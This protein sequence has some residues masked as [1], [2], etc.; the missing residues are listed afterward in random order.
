MPG[1]SR[2]YTAGEKERLA[3]LERKKKGIP[4]NKKLQEE[5]IEMRDD[6]GLTS[7]RFPF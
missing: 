4:L 3:W 1:E 6:L 5:I 2:I 7:Y